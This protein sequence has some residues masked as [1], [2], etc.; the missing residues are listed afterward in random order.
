MLDTGADDTIF[1]LADAAVLGLDLT[2]APIHT[3]QGIGGPVHVV[4]YAQL[5]FRITDGVE[6]RE[7]PARVGFTTAA[8]HR[9]LL[10]FSG[11]L[12]FFTATFY[13]DAEKV[14]LTIN[15]LYPG[16]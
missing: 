12:Q 8:M 13:G 2:N 16:T 1:P 15:S 6:F 3:F 5:T 9:P 4:R 14:E 10:G 11:F 7:W